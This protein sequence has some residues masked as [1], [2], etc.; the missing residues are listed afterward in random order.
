MSEGARVRLAASRIARLETYQPEAQR[1][2]EL[3]DASGV[4]AHWQ[5]L[6]D[7]LFADDDVDT[8]RRRLELTR[9]LIVENGVTYNIYADSQGADRPWRL[10]PLPL[11]LPAGEWREI[12]EGVLQRAHLLDLLLADL[13]GPQRLLAEGCVPAALAYGHPN[14]LWPC[15]GIVPP[16]GQW[17]HVYAADIARAP[18]GRWWLLA[19]RTQ[20]PSGAGYALENREITEQVLSEALRDLRVRRVR[21]CFASFREQL[22]SFAESQDTPLAVVL[23]PGPF[24]ETY[25][26]HTYLARQLGLPLAEGHD[27]TVRDDIVYLK[28]LGGLRR[29][30]TIYRRLDDDY[31]DP[32][33]LRS[34]SA[35]GVPGLLGAVR[36]GQ[37]VLANALGSGVLESA[38]WLGFIPGV[39]ERLLGEPLKL[40]SVAT[41]WCG[42]EAALDYVLAHFDHIVIKPSYPNQR[43]EPVF[44]RQLGQEARQRL[45][46]SLR[47]RPYAY[48]AQEHLPLSQAPTWRSDAKGFAATPLSLR[49][50]VI[51][52]PQGRVVMPGG[53]VRVATETAVDV[54]SSQ[55]GG[56]SKDLWVLAAPD[57]KELTTTS[58]RVM[59][60]LSHGEEAPSRLVENL[61]WFGRYC[62]R[63]EDKARLIRAT[64]AVGADQ[65]LARAA[66]RISRELGI[67]EADLDS[68]TSLRDLANPY[69]IVADVKRLGW[70]ASQVR[71]RLSSSFWRASVDL[72]LQLQDAVARTEEPREALDRLL[73]SLAALAGYAFDHMTRDEGWRLM[74]IG[75]R[76]ERLQ[77]LAQLLS[78]FVA[79]DSATQQ[80]HI[81]W[82][83]NG[84]ES[85]RVYR[86]R[87]VVAPRL[88]PTLDLLL[89]DVEHPRAI[90]FQHEAISK[91]L[92][93]LAAALGSGEV[94]LDRTL[95][96][97][98]DASLFL[99]EADTEEA[100]CA[101]VDLAEHLQS[102]SLAAASL[103]DR[104]SLRYFS[105]IESDAQALAT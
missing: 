44:G 86:S 13:Y 77:F 60:G 45:I 71:S 32:V 36:C 99:L 82:L 70:C 38:A 89:R 69:G 51:A 67:I 23:T 22:L 54:V 42:E 4:R 78:R 9:R 105:L 93:A 95:R 79:S 27:L 87:Y 47:A 49:V 3:L 102:V 58:S 73:L 12:E 97:L 39:A 34:D 88:G 56:G 63:C 33:E 1:Y 59:P 100:Q 26:E 46:A 19:D 94:R 11:V 37:V 21:E 68:R 103:S 48:V 10:D 52:T 25:F 2:D 92:A 29:V 66:V 15:R 65:E 74:R 50:Y 6:I 35:L 64:L 28:T 17:L 72:Q 14:F 80:D 81:E 98:G 18:D 101:R 75:R 8:A 61:Y 84:C 5:P 7:P 41:W 16:G 76:L 62:V 40:P 31:C 104:I 83:L 43:F 30:H 20:A 85:A 57:T 90:A 24:N 96:T 55:R 91:D 53:L